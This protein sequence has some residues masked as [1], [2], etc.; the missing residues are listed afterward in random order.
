[1]SV[2]IQLIPKPVK[3]E[4]NGTGILPAYRIPWP[5]HLSPAFQ[6]KCNIFERDWSLSKLKTLTGEMRDLKNCCILVASYLGEENVFVSS[7]RDD[8]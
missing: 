5:E 4:V 7:N 2:V 6:A 3:Q 1:M 8:F